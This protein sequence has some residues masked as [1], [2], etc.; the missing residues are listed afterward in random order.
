MGEQWYNHNDGHATSDPA[1]RMGLTQALDLDELA[2]V[3]TAGA[4]TPATTLAAIPPV[5][6][7][8]TRSPARSRRR[9]STPPR[10]RSPAS[11]S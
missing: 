5:A 2:S 10:P 9:T 7:P 4:G 8:V 11:P 3:A 6:C 1:V